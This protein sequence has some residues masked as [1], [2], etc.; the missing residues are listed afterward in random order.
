MKGPAKRRPCWVVLAPGKQKAIEKVVFADEDEDDE[1][2]RT[3][4]VAEGKAG[5]VAIIE[6]EPGSEC[7]G[8]E[9][10]AK[11]LS[12]GAKKPAYVLWLN[13]ESP[14]VQ[15]FAK[16]VY[17]GEVSAYPDT[18]ARQLGCS[19]PTML[20]GRNKA[21]LTA[22]KSPKAKQGELTIG[23]FT[24]AQ[25]KHEM[26]YDG[27]WSVLLDGA[28]E[29]TAAAALEALAHEDW[30]VREVAC[31]LVDVM[32]IYGYP[33][34]KAS[35]A[36]AR[37]RAVATSDSHKKVRTAAQKAAHELAEAIETRDVRD[38]KLRTTATS[39]ISSIR[40]KLAE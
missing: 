36:L 34:D 33:D 35:D 3:I 21:D 5:Y 1:D 16:G 40:E 26:K 2:E 17:Q 19:F 37:L 6:Y 9:K 22:R 29:Q 28:S 11:T 31:R 25:W 4:E 23:G 32:S 18:V 10:L 38:P 24:I 7:T 30:D 15:A 20:K 14:R 27:D 12:T 39:A 8:D 13:D